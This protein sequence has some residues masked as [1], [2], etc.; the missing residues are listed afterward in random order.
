MI[1]SFASHHEV[2]FFSTVSFSFQ[3]TKIS[4][5]ALFSLLDTHLLKFFKTPKY[6]NGPASKTQINFLRKKGKRKNK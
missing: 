4:P 3:L 6:K 1:Q 5:F 2:N